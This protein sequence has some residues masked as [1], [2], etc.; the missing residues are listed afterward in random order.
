MR[1]ILLATLIGLSLVAATYDATPAMAGSDEH[2]KATCVD[3]PNNSVTGRVITSKAIELHY[4]S[5][6][7]EEQN[8]LPLLYVSGPCKNTSIP[9][10]CANKR[11]LT[12]NV[13]LADPADASKMH[14][15]ERVTLGGVFQIVTQNN[16]DYLVVR[17]AKVLH[18][19]PFVQSE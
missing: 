15:G 3:V 5:C 13:E 9:T 8:S 16:G 11:P 4:F 17:D 2:L 1:S 14:P 12:M 18:G 6:R 19:D 10:S 7:R